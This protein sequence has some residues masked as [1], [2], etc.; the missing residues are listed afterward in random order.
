MPSVET[1]TGT[2]IH[3]SKQIEFRDFKWLWKW[4]KYI[5][6]LWK[7]PE[8]STFQDAGFCK[9]DRS[10]SFGRVWQA[11]GL[12][13]RFT[14]PLFY[15]SI[16]KTQRFLPCFYP[17]LVLR[18][19]YCLWRKRGEEGPQIMCC[20]RLEV[21]IW[22]C[23]K[24]CKRSVR[25]RMCV[26]ERDGELCVCVRCECFFWNA[27]HILP[28]VGEGCVLWP[29]ASFGNQAKCYVLPT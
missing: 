3:K 20:G 1:N 12:T 5:S 26:C 15:R 17:C 9:N 16:T 25:E 29:N 23:K 28:T 13:C 10:V 18:V 6:L 11:A 21:F 4:E 7:T 22:V 27:S 24:K 14:T 2:N 8:M 19:E